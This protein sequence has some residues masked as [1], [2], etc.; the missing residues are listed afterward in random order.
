M[1]HRH[2]AALSLAAL[3]L[4]V[5]V[6]LSGCATTPAPDLNPLRS[7]DFERDTFG[8]VNDLYWIYRFDPETGKILETRPNEGARHGQRCVAMARASRQFLY[9]ARF[10][11]DAPRIE[12]DEY[13]RRVRRILDTNP[14][15]A[16]RAQDPIVIPGYAGLRAFSAEHAEMIWPEL[17]ARWESY[18]QRGNWRM[19]MP[20]SPSQQRETVRKLEVSLARGRLPIIRAMNFPGVNLNHTLIVFDIESTPTEVYIQAY[21]PN[22]NEKPVRLVFERARARFHYPPTA[23]FPGGTAKV[24]EI[25]DGWLL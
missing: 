15:K 12:P 21:D 7:F 9:H 1:G 18:L 24:Y 16:Q 2:L 13:R 6:G 11:P 25:Y 4:A 10:E 22:Q 19:V 3:S 17:G 14:R 8:F 5:L 20:F 23:Y